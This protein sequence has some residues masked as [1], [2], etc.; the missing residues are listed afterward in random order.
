M[1]QRH[2]GQADEEEDDREQT[3][4]I[5]SGGAGYENTNNQSCRDKS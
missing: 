4:N 1:C 2:R 5:F 3:G